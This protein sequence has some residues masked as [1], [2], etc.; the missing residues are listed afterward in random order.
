[1][2]RSQSGAAIVE[3]I[4]FVPIIFLMTFMALEL[5]NFMRVHSAVSWVAEYGVRQ[6][7]EGMDTGNQR[8]SQEVLKERVVLK[9]FGLNIFNL[10]FKVCAEY[11]SSVSDFPNKPTHCNDEH[12]SDLGAFAK[13][14]DFVRLTV[15]VPYQPMFP[16]M[17]YIGDW[18]TGFPLNAQFIRI[19]SSEYAP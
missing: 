14:G 5:T 1:M 10:E 8:Y 4:I 2:R 3:T 7:S 9:M 13:T 19:L 16:K 11:A 6:A 15:V 12:Y 17:P 18:I